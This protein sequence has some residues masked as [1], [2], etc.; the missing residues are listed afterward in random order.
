M[1]I[2]EQ[3]NATDEHNHLWHNKLSKSAQNSDIFNRFVSCLFRGHSQ[4]RF[5]A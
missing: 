3:E 1:S 5:S 2:G 4:E